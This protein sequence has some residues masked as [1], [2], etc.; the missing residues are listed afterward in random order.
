MSAQSNR[1]AIIGKRDCAIIGE[2]VEKAKEGQ[3]CFRIWISRHEVDLCSLMKTATTG[4]KIAPVEWV[5]RMRT[6]FQY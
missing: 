5:P 6:P 2:L 1:T 3:G 4:F